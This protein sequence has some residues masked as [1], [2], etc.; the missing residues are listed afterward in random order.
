M[1]TQAITTL[2]KY[3][4]RVPE[5]TQILYSEY[6]IRHHV[7]DSTLWFALLFHLNKKSSLNQSNVSRL[8]M[9]KGR[10][11]SSS[12]SNVSLS[13]DEIRD[14]CVKGSIRLCD[15]MKNALDSCGNENEDD[16]SDDK[17]VG[18]E[19]TYFNALND[20]TTFSSCL[21]H[22]PSLSQF[23]VNAL[24]NDKDQV[25]E[26]ISKVLKSLM[27]FQTRK[28]NAAKNI[29]DSEI[30]EVND[31]DEYSK[32]TKKSKARKVHDYNSVYNCDGIRSSAKSLLLTI[33]NAKFQGSSH[34][35]RVS[36]KTD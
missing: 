2:G 3:A 32:K 14:L 4:S 35:V 34:N 21:R 9:V 27:A 28:K 15:N 36:S 19:D 1:S 29:V 7:V 18:M 17:K 31:D 12:S 23:W 5:L 8:R 16:G 11:T 30:K 13:T 22:V 25:Q 6:F 10:S 26:S 33:D 20:F 24:S